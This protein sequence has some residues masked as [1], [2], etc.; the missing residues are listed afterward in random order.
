MTAPD[1]FHVHLYRPIES[2]RS[3]K[4][5]RYIPYSCLTDPGDDDVLLCSHSSRL[6]DPYN[7]F[8]NNTVHCLLTCELPVCVWERCVSSHMKC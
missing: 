8:I 1:M 7:Y 3:P 2:P 6:G 4:L 5:N